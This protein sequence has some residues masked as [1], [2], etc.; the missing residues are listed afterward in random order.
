MTLKSNDAKDY[1]L[2]HGLNLFNKKIKLRSYDDVLHDEYTEYLQ[3]EQMQKKL[4]ASKQQLGTAAGVD[5]LNDP[6]GYCE[7]LQDDELEDLSGLHLGDA[8]RGPPS[9][10]VNTPEPT[11]SANSRV[12]LTTSSK[13]ELVL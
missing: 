2:Y 6:E 11:H 4:Y 13:T 8:H 3:Y 5:E 9:T 7:Q 12:L 1:L 10:A